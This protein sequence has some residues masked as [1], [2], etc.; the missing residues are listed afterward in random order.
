MPALTPDVFIAMPATPQDKGP[1]GPLAESIHQTRLRNDER[2]KHMR[3]RGE[4]VYR[5]DPEDE[6]KEKKDGS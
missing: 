6:D 1:R 3:E 2:L 5:P 4:L